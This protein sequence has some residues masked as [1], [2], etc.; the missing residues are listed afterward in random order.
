MAFQNPTMMP[1]RTT[2]DNILL[3]LE[4]VEPHKRA[5]GTIAP[6]TRRKAMKLLQTVGLADFARQAIPGSS[7]AACS[8]APTSAAP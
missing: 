5:S 7:R 2:I 8:S 6:S 4:I 1:W 3:P